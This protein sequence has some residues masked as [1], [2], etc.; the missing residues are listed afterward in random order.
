MPVPVKSVMLSVRFKLG[1]LRLLE[2]AAERAGKR[3]A[4]WVR[5]TVLQHAETT[6]RPLGTHS[7]APLPNVTAGGAGES[8]LIRFTSPE[9]KKIEQAASKHGIKFSTYVRAVCMHML[10]SSTLMR[11]VVVP[12]LGSSK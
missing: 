8:L 10:S 12:A 2:K 4:T 5:E 11:A 6:L 9:R 1:T 3:R 7:V